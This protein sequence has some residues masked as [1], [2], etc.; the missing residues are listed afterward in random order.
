MT[1]RYGIELDCNGYA[2]SI[3][4]E[5]TGESCFLCGANGRADPLNRHEIFGG[6]YRKKSKM[7]GLWVSLCHARCHQF[8][9]RAAHNNAEINLT[10]RRRGQ[11]A[12]MRVY[13]WTT[14]DFIREFGKNYLEDATC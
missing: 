3:V 4:Q 6:A 1:N 2:P 7:A 8:G 13:S 11:Q 12:A 5:D 9:E 14:A 10:L